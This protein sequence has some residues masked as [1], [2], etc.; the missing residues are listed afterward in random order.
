MAMIYIRDETRNR[1]NKLI[2]STEKPNPFTRI[3]QD[4]ILTKALDKLE[5]KQ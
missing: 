1:I 5:G 2:N 4:Y 3:T